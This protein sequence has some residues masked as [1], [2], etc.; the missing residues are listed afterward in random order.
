MLEKSLK[1]I[2]SIYTKRSL[3]YKNLIQ[4]ISSSAIVQLIAFLTTPLLTRIYSPSDFGKFASYVSLIS[5]FAVI[6]TLRYEHAIVIPTKDKKAKILVLICFILIVI[7][8]I[9]FLLFGLIQINYSLI[10]KNNSISDVYWFIPFGILFSGII[11][12]LNYYAI[13][14]KLFLFIS[15]LQIKQSLFGLFV[16]ILSFKLG[17]SGLIIGQLSNILIGIIGFTNLLGKKLFSI[18]PINK[19]SIKRV[20][21]EYKN[22]AIFSTVSGLVNTFGAKVPYLLILIIFGSKQLGYLYLAEKLLRAPLNLL[23]TSIQKVFLG[24]S[25]EYFRKGKMLKLINKTYIKLLAMNICVGAALTLILPLIISPIFG[26]NWENVSK[27]ILIILPMTLTDFTVS[28]LSMSFEIIKKPEDGLYAQISLSVIRMIPFCFPILR[29]DF[30]N[31][32]IFYSISSSFGYISYY[33]FLKRSVYLSDKFNQYKL[34][35]Y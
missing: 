10:S 11:Q 31:L 34:E 6:S 22:F 7:T 1:K 19:L 18:F 17:F 20:A 3:T 24:I 5:I 14:D 2:I 23:S 9:L 12:P 26:S 30:T 21:S 35:R 15:K 16:T 27:I 25:P 29:L 28:T 33:F 32:M 13:R 8:F 4:L